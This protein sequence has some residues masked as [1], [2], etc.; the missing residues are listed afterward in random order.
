MV[1]LFNSKQLLKQSYD[2]LKDVCKINNLGICSGEGFIYGDIM[3]S[4][5]QSIEKILDT[6]LES[7][8]VLMVDECHEFCSRSKTLAAIEAFPN[9][10]WRFG[11]TATVPSEPIKRCNLE[12]A[13]GVLFN[14][15]IHKS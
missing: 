8:E 12:G 10:S 1:I 13:L 9:A 6:H 2:F 5:V 11:F 15:L 14:Q 4:T 7:A 3:M